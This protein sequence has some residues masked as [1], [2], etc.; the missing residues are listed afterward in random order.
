MK[1]GCRIAVVI[2]AYNE[3]LAIARTLQNLPSWVD[4]AVVVDDASVDATVEAVH[5]FLRGRATDAAGEKQFVGPVQ[6][7]EHV[8]NQGVGRAIVS[9]YQRAL[10]GG[11]DCLVVMA[12]DDQMS[13]TDLPQLVAPV[14]LGQAHYAKGNRFIHASMRNM[15]LH[16]RWGGRVLSA[17]TA[18]MTGL[19]VGDSQCGYTA[20]G[21]SA[22][23]SLPLEQ[24]WPRFG[25]PNDLLGMLSQASA[26]V[27]EVPVAAVYADEASGIR[28]YHLAVV[29]FVIF[30]RALLRFGSVR[31]LFHQRGSERL[32]ESTLQTPSCPNQRL[33]HT[34][35]SQ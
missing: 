30:R 12:G 19:D 9:G 4:F 3:Q 11:A 18:A 6:L 34:A 2:P 10:A 15:P 24:L 23:R 13:P 16:R 31:R 8:E 27:V 35:R 14:V 26:M 33:E 17:L 32:C 7:V 22:A 29:T 20:I 21:A 28:W 5:E 25:Y 1:F